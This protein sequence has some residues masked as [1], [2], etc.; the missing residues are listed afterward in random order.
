MFARDVFLVGERSQLS[1]HNGAVTYEMGSISIDG[2]AT[3]AAP[4][5]LSRECVALACT[6]PTCALRLHLLP[7]TD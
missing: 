4:V 3:S 2:R 5:P 1:Y 6:A 7:T